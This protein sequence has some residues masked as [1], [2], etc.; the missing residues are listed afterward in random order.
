MPKSLEL[1]GQLWFMGS[2]L[3][4]LCLRSLYFPWNPTVKPVTALLL[5]NKRLTKPGFVA[6]AL[7]IIC[8]FLVPSELKSVSLR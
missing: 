8:C 4:F 1:L 5:C 3:L 6:L 7:G 2:T